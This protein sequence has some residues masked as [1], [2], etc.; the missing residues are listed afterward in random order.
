MPH[1]RTVLKELPMVV[2]MRGDEEICAEFSLDA[3]GA[4]AALGIKRTRLT[5]VSGRELRVGRRRL[6]RYIK[7]F[8]RPI[9]IENYLRWTRRSA[10]SQNATAALSKASEELESRTASL[11][12]DLYGV[13]GQL[14]ILLRRAVR[15]RLRQWESV[16]L[17]RFRSDP[18]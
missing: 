12:E 11:S 14:P 5:Q 10:T 8:Y 9:D 2:W 7:P 15:E 17:R 1:K 13:V 3:D 6:G 4:M 18:S 16:L